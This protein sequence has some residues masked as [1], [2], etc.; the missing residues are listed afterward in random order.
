M[1]SSVVYVY[2]R[3]QTPLLSDEASSQIRE[4]RCVVSNNTN[5]YKVSNSITCTFEC[6]HCDNPSSMKIKKAMRLLTW[7]AHV[8]NVGKNVFIYIS[9]CIQNTYAFS[10][11]IYHQRS[12]CFY[13]TISLSSQP[14][15]LPVVLSLLLLSRDWDSRVSIITRQYF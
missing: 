2:Y 4:H 8:S 13:P 14:S 5:T 1:R 15:P 12:A 6:I 7:R 3:P 10:L 9:R 11:H